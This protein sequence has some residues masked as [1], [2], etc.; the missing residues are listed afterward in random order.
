MRSAGYNYAA[1]AGPAA[2][3]GQGP[4]P[5]YYCGDVPSRTMPAPYPGPGSWR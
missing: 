5:A 4:A 2:S 1:P 3:Y